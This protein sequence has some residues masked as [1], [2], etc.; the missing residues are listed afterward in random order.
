MST[1]ALTLTL[2][3]AGTAA[4]IG[5]W[6]LS[7][8]RPQAESPVSASRPVNSPARPVT[9]HT[10]GEQ[11]VAPAADA[12]GQAALQA[13]GI[14]PVEPAKSPPSPGKLPAAQPA[15]SIE[16]MTRRAEKVEQEANHDLKRLVGLLNLD[17]QQ[18]DRVFET[19][20]RHSSSWVPG[21]QVGGVASTP[22]NQTTPPV[23]GDTAAAST[24]TD[25]MEEIMA[26]L[27]PEQQDAL[28]QEEMDRTAWWAEIL[29]QITPPDEVP[30]LDGGSQAYEGST[31]LD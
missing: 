9:R 28:L 26:L 14:R 11:S 3:L 21:M 22:G 4:G 31:T 23:S 17:E 16:E 19:L 8:H 6:A 13:S 1:R 7:G 20:A 2:C 30:S 18:Q 24:A 29:P 25:P 15:L 10:S 27:S 12:P 5:L